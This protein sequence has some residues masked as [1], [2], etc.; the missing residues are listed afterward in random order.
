M[1]LGGASFN[2]SI[3][4]NF[5]RRCAHALS[6]SVIWVLKPLKIRAWRM[7][8]GWFRR[9]I[10]EG[11]SFVDWMLVFA[12]VQ[13][14]AMQ[15]HHRVYRGNFIFGK[16]LMIVD[17]ERAAREI[18][19]P[20][21]RGNRFMGVDLVSNDPGAF[22]T[23]AGPITTADPVR[24]LARGYIDQQVMTPRVRALD[25]AA[26]RTE[27]AA[28]LADWSADPRMA[29]MWSIRGAVTRLMLRIL[30]QQGLPKAAADAITFNYTRRFVEFSLFGR[31]CPFLLGLLGTREGVRRDAYLPLRRL[32][33]DNM[34]IDMTLFA[35]MFSLGTIVIKAVGFA[36]EFD[37]DYGRLQPWERMAFVVE[38]LRYCPT[39]T[40]V[41][42]IVEED[43]TAEVAGRTLPL[44]PGD[45][46]AY[47]FVCINRDPRQFAD[48]STFRIN[49]PREEFERVLSWSTGPHVCPAKDLSILVTVLMLD[50]LAARFDL[51]KLRIFNLEF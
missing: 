12:N 11:T 13:N 34:I 24:R 40:S 23:N 7:R 38:A 49:R 42:R 37:L 36:A 43:E 48:P 47:P 6:L 3:R 44:R 28:E 8:L 16:A 21:L 1:R 15:L 46:V 50:A 17:H 10:F 18:A 45:E 19:R 20:A 39:V 22:V 51:R 41:H 5:L 14:A 30:A 33:V 32:G 31:Y 25:L 2:R 9:L 35:A 26:L 27:C 29:T 4:M